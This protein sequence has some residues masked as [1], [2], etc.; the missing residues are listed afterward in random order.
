MYVHTHS[1]RKSGRRR[2]QRDQRELKAPQ[3]RSDEET[4]AVPAE[5]VRLERFLQLT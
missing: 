5:S 1:R 3:E 4:E 2:L